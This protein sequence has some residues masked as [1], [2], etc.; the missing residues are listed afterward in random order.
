MKASPIHDVLRVLTSS[1]VLFVWKASPRLK[2]AAFSDSFPS[3][4]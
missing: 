1:E 3:P 2:D 4:C